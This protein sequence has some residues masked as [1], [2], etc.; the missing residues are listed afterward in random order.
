MEANL[1]SPGG[2]SSAEMRETRV[3]KG[4]GKGLAKGKDQ[5]S[6]KGKS[7][8]KTKGKGKKTKTK[9]TR[10]TTAELRKLES[11]CNARRALENAT[12]GLI[13]LT[14][15]ELFDYAVPELARA[16]PHARSGYAA[17][18]HWTRYSDRNIKYI[19]FLSAAT[20]AAAKKKKKQQA[21]SDSCTDG[22]VGDM[23]GSY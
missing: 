9:T 1:T 20:A 18:M 2:A 12:P 14:I 22:D 23:G 10:W 17:Y 16:F 21:G 3:E 4:K 19:R 6:S 11:I 13:P 15:H 7:K 5:A 8:R